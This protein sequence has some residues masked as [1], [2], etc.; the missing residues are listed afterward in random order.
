M[1]AHCLQAM[2]FAPGR[3]PSPHWRCETVQ[4]LHRPQQRGKT[5]CQIEKL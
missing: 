3:V 5:V 1:L 4:D 2:R